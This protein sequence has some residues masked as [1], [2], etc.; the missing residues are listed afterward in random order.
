MRSAWR[1]T[2][3][4]SIGRRGP[5]AARTLA[6]R[7]LELALT[8]EPG[9]TVSA[10]MITTVADQHSRLAVDFVLAHLAQVNAFRER[11]FSASDDS[12]SRARRVV[13]RNEQPSLT[14]LFR[15]PA[16]NRAINVVF[17]VLLVLSV[18][19]AFAF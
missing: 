14:S 2:S 19:L 1:R 10:G 5:G 11:A 17:A 6:R 18:A 15:D 7:T 4:A 9:S 12:Q 16:S 8:K 3:E 13:D